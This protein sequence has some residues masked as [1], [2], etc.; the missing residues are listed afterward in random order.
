MAFAVRVEGKVLVD[1]VYEHEEL[2]K[3][4]WLAYNTGDYDPSDFN[5]G[6]GK[7]TPSKEFK[8]YPEAETVR[9]VVHT[10]EVVK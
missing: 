10:I 9:V 5:H 8:R 2:S 3:M 7:L 4:H 6:E 1:T